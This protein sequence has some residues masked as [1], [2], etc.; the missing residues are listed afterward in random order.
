[1]K[2]VLKKCRFNAMPPYVPCE[3]L[4]APITNSHWNYTHIYES[5]TFTSKPEPDLVDLRPNEILE[6]LQISFILST[7][8]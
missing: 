5:Y 3:P 1:M 4:R 6:N 8:L 7:I 2:T